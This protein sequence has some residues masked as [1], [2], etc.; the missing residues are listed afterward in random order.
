MQTLT[1]K[2]TVHT[3]LT[4]SYMIYV[5]CLLLGFFTHSLFKISLVSQNLQYFG[6]L[7]MVLSPLLISAAQRA[8]RKFKTVR[9]V[10][11]VGPTDFMYGPYK[12][13]QSPTH[14][15]I[16][17]L[18]MGFSIVMNS[19]AL[20]LATLMAYLITHLFFLPAEQKVLKKKYGAVYE[21]YLKMVK[22]SI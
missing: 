14:F 13:L 19:F 11:E 2:K 7:C 8:S 21:V 20:V 17:L 4:E 5:I 22:L 16:F 18:S 15:G 3:I 12:Y 6:V 10:R 1:F 9:L